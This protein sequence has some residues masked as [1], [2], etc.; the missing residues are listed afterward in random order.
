MGTIIFKIIMVAVR[1]VTPELKNLLSGTLSQLRKQ[2]KA[3]ASPWDDLLVE[4]LYSLLDCEED[5]GLIE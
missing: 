5:E 2:A 3:T 1:A 4:I